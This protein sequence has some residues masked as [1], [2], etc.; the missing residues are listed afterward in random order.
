MIESG[1]LPVLL[2]TSE[3]DERPNAAVDAMQDMI[4]DNFK[5]THQL[6]HLELPAGRAEAGSKPGEGERLAEIFRVE[7]F[8]QLVVYNHSQKSFVRC[9]SDDWSSSDYRIMACLERQFYAYL[10]SLSAESRHSLY[11]AIWASDPEQVGLIEELLRDDTQ[12]D[13]D[14]DPEEEFLDNGFMARMRRRYP[15]L[16]KLI[17]RPEFM[18][19]LILPVTLMTTFMF[20]GSSDTE[21][22]DF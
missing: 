2:F 9:P 17:L 15:A 1:L 3:A 19:V 13:H 22:D 14:D 16:A 20:P 11:E 21:D 4:M 18:L 8:P 12:E 6:A 5:L 10:R 7:S